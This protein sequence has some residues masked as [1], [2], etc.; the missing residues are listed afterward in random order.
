MK[1][2]KLVTVSRKW[3]NP[4]IYIDIT[5]EGIELSMSLD[6]FVVALADEVGSIALTVRDATFRKKLADAAE[7]VVSGIKDES[8]KAV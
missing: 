6:D 5:N 8:R 2:S 4:Q 1:P 3:N 7:R